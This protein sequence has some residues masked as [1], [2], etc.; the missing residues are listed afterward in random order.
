MITPSPQAGATI[1]AVKIRAVT[2]GLDL[3]PQSEVVGAPIQAAGR[4]LAA[5]KHAFGA[6]GIE[7]Q[8]TRAAGPALRPAPAGFATWAASVERVARD[9]GIEYLSFGRLPAGSHEFV[10]HELAPILAQSEIGFFS[11]DLIDGRLPSVAMAQACARSV[12]QLAATTELGFGNLRLAATANCPPNIPFLPAAYHAGGPPQFSIAVEAADVV[13]RAFDAPGGM[14]EI[15]DRLV[16]QLELACEPVERVADALSASH[17]YAFAG[18]DLSPAPFPADEASIGA[19]VE[20]AGVDRFGAPGTLY[21]A[22]MITRAIRRTRVR[23]C[24]FSGLML[25][26]LEDSV[27]ARRAAECAPTLHELLLFSAVCGTGLDTIPLPGDVSE[28][29]LAGIYLDV[30]ALSVALNGKPLTVRLM[31]VPGADAGDWTRYTFDYFANSRVL[32]SASA[33]AAGVLE[34]GQ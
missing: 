14:A 9:N 28:A 23:R 31:P 34:R 1:S 30:A 15:E 8:T 4:F 17:G 26:L 20:R 10:S 18:I 5:A 25:P 27:L 22:A 24:G 6:A 2:V 11:V 29:E 21:I 3:Q 32:R 16:Q 7:V 19:A 12:K 33:G 13:V